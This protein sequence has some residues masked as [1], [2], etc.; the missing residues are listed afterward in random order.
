[1]NFK[2]I[3]LSSLI[4][5]VIGAMLGAAAAEINQGDR[6]PD[7]PLYYTFAGAVMGLLVGGGQEALRQLERERIDV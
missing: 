2:C 1:M 7:A 4:T 5:C 3:L 6:N